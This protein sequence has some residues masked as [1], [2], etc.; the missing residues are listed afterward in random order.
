MTDRWFGTPGGPTVMVVSHEASRTGAP[1]VAAHLLTALRKAG[2][3]TIVLHRWGGPMRR[4]LDDAAGVGRLEPMSHLRVLLRRSR[5]TKALAGLIERRAI[6]RVL[7]R[8]RPDVVWCNTVLTAVYAP[9]AAARGIPCVVYSHEARPLCEPA[10]A[11]VG[12]LASPLPG[13]GEV[14]WVGCSTETSEVLDDLMGTPHT[15]L[16]LNSPVDVGAVRNAAASGSESMGRPTVVAA[17][18]GDIRKGVAV[19]N[20]AATIGADL[21]CDW[22]WV[23]EVPPHSRVSAVDYRGELVSA[24]PTIARSDV[25][26]LPSLLDSFPL[27]VLEAMALSKP[28]VAS[29]LPGTVE[30]LGDTGVLVDPGDAV[31]LVDAVAELLGDRTRA[32]ELGAAAAERCTRLWDIVAFERRVGEILDDVV[33]REGA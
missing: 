16:V 15:A 20:E 10:L 3:R 7:D 13:R 11:R 2:A 22:V 6:G 29:R 19:F 14:T 31:A 30:Q 33:R 9:A 17:G 21:A 24:V 12:L 32:A 25:F 1:K 28:V 18:K 26:V 23:G 4:E 5:R 8:V 27:V